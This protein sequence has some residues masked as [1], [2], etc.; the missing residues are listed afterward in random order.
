[1]CLNAFLMIK[2]PSIFLLYY[3][4]AMAETLPETVGEVD[5]ITAAEVNFK[6][7]TLV[8]DFLQYLILP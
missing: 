3:S 4:F 6:Q 7:K 1:M 5:V 8:T 2:S